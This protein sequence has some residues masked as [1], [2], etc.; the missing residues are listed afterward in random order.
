MIDGMPDEPYPAAHLIAGR[1]TGPSGVAT[2]CT[3]GLGFF[4][5]YAGRAPGKF[6]TDEQ[7]RNAITAADQLWH[8]HEAPYAGDRPVQ[9]EMVYSSSGS[10]V[11]EWRCWPPSEGAAYVVVREEWD[12]E[13]SPPVR[14]IHEI[15]LERLEKVEEG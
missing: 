9:R 8:E 3:C 11:R 10:Y 7:R 13:A 14:V 5:H 15:R 1:M 4:A 2:F 6:E 12:N